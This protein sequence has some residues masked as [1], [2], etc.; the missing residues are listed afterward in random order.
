[1]GSSDQDLYPQAGGGERSEFARLL[2][3]HSPAVLKRMEGKI[4]RRWRAV[5]SAEDV[6]QQTCTDAFLHFEQFV[7]QTEGSFAAW[8]ST[9][10]QRNLLN[11]LRM[12]DTEKRGGKYRRVE[13]LSEEDSFFALYEQVEA[14]QSTPSRHVVRDEARAALAHAIRR[15]PED[16]RRVVQMFDLEGKLVGEVAQALNRSPGAVYMIRA[17][18][19]HWLGEFMGS[20]T[21]YF[22][23]V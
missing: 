15:L 11:A 21:K 12:L 2:V 3:E 13:P 17:R 9:I 23:G 6:L 4:P 1:M 18:A 16:Y 10:A 8:L 20:A 22:S 5:L 7:S 14:L 19:H